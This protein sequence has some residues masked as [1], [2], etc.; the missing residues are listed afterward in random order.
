M[1][2]GTLP[3]VHSCRPA[4]IAQKCSP[5]PRQ[6]LWM[7][8]L[9][10]LSF[11]SLNLF[12]SCRDRTQRPTLAFSNQCWDWAS[13]SLCS[14]HQGAVYLLQF[15][16]CD[17]CQLLPFTWAL[18][19]VHRAGAGLSLHKGVYSAASLFWLE[20]SSLVCVARWSHCDACFFM[21][22]VGTKLIFSV[23][24]PCLSQMLKHLT[25]PLS[26][27]ILTLLIMATLDV[28]KNI[29]L[30]E[31]FCETCNLLVWLFKTWWY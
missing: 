1:V 29:P 2:L 19:T 23:D 14:K 5:F 12:I 6:K 25:Q 13:H 7:R 8:N 3:F 27:R 9:W 16:G 22:F 21:E 18:G 28:N 30:Y 15:R 20:L 10:V 24:P 17:Y 31:Y 4:S 11:P 26:L